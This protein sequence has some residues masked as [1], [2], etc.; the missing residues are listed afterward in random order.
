MKK[1]LLKEKLNKIVLFLKNSYTLLSGRKC[2]EQFFLKEDIETV[3]QMLQKLPLH[4][5]QE[6]FFSINDYQIYFHQ[7]EIDEKILI[8][9]AAYDLALKEVFSTQE[10]ARFKQDDEV[11][12]NIFTRLTDFCYKNPLT[13][14]RHNCKS[15]IDCF[16]NH[17]I[18]TADW[19][20]Y[21]EEQ[22][23][24]FADAAFK[25]T[26]ENE[27]GEEEKYR[28]SALLYRQNKSANPYY[29]NA[30]TLD[31]INTPLLAKLHLIKECKKF[32]NNCCDNLFI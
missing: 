14:D 23:L 28:L 21:E 17:N 4:Y 9:A 7:S 11:R 32:L 1:I 24:P 6:Y 19:Y 10:E 3:S 27:S 29:H 25:I 16:I 12:K 26:I 20:Y 8:K 18:S 2:L 22:K 5:G 13:M 31:N 30:K 15:W